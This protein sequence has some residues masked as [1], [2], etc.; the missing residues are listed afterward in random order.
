MSPHREKYFL[1]R[2]RSM[3]PGFQ[4]GDLLEIEPVNTERLRIG[5]CLLFQD[6]DGQLV[7]HRLIEKDP[8]LLTRGDALSRPDSFNILPTDIRGRVIVRCRYEQCEKVAG[9]RFGALAAI[10]YRYAGRI[11]PDRASRGGRL[12]RAIQRASSILLKPLWQL[13]KIRSLHIP[14]KGSIVVWEMGGNL[15]G[16]KRPEND[17]WQ[18]FWPWRVFVKRPQGFM[19]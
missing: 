11:D 15:I 4:D 12:A 19:R 5:D 6:P 8:A 7:V 17:D 14:G 16:R 10:F 3:W 13:G 1:Y 9:G 18:I 2:G